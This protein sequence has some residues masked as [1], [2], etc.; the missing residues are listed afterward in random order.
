MMGQ[1]T[2]CES[3]FYYFRIEDY[4]PEDHLLRLI[5][6]YVDFGFVRET[7]KESYSHTGRPSIDPEVLLRIL[8][9]GY[10]Y[11]IT[12]ER[13]LVEDVGMHLAYRWFTGLGFDQDVPHHSTFSKNRHG[14]FQESPVF[15]ELFE[16]IVQQCM[17]VGLLKGVDL[18]VDSTRF[19]PMPILTGQSLVSNF[20]R[21]PKLIAACASTWSRSSAR[22]L[23]RSRHR[24][25][26]DLRPKRKASP[27]CAAPLGT[28]HPS[29]FQRPT[30]K[31]RCQASEEHRNSLTTITI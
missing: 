28:R 29:R 13:R 30:R 5:D 19:A 8:L 10:L 23:S 12:S 1:Q 25:L 24:P 7:L 9:F 6:R 31:R 3:L 18:S 15:L 14:R 21:S 17:N 16:R 2:R 20:R 26:I 27:N 4:V 22:T 11:G